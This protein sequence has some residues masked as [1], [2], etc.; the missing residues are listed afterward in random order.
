MVAFFM[1]VANA[2]ALSFVV[3]D[4]ADLPD[5]D[6]GDANICDAGLTNGCTLRAALEEADSPDGAIADQITVSVP[7]QINLT[8]ALAAGGIAAGPLTVTG[9]PS[10]TTI[11]GAGSFVVIF[12]N[13]SSVTLEDLTIQNGKAADDAAGA[14]ISSSVSTLL[15][16]NRVTVKT[17]T[18]G[19]TAAS[20]AGIRLF[21][22]GDLTL[23]D[24]TVSGNTITGTGG[25][26]AGIAGST[27]ASVTINRSTVSGNKVLTATGSAGGMSLGDNGDHVI[28][29]STF[30][31]NETGSGGGGG[32][33]VGGATSV[34]IL[35]S[36]FAENKATGGSANGGGYLSFTPPTVKNTIFSQ[37]TS[38]VA[39]TENCAGS[40]P[41]LPISN[42]DSGTS[43]AMGTTNGNQE[44]VS[45]AA[46][47]LGLLANNGGFTETRAL[48][49]GSAAIGT[50]DLTTCTTSPVSSKDQRGTTR[51]QQGTCEVG[52]FEFV[53]A[54][55]LP[56]L[57][58]PNTLIS[59]GPK[60]RT[61]KAKAKFLFSSSEVGSRFTCKLDKKPAASCT[62]PKTFKVK[63]G[64]HKVLIQ[65][66]DAAGN[67]DAS[68]ASFKW[69]R[70]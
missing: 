52:A 36:T 16:L 50:G 56:D 21:S 43:C 69:R 28:V 27:N 47:A 62:S 13:G 1:L 49:A 7:G 3:D 24:S 23:N 35:N 18:V 38:A 58:A 17:N 39:G 4:L 46:L 41:A 64:K 45:P 42:I 25:V 60:K 54:P 5:A 26:G 61:P 67:A 10:S 15:T 11:D 63:V 29:N 14:G 9:H 44:N 12:A 40:N 19:G 30:S 37:N 55:V 57:L 22:S 53:P 65:A 2:S 48:G 6:S 59:K 20:G 68:P 51:P 33:R 66:I 34:T 8:A 70:I 31:G 32:F